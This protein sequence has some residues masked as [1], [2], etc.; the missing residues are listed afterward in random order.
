MVKAITIFK[1]QC[2]KKLF[3]GTYCIGVELNQFFQAYLES[4][5]VF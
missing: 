2:K 5:A 3:I 1:D 4:F